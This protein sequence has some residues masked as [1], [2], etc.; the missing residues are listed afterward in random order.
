MMIWRV[1]TGLDKVVKKISTFFEKS[2]DKMTLM[3]YTYIRC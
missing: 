1:V 3:P 2:V